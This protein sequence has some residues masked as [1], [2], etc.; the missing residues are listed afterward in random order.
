MW[1]TILGRSPI[2]VDV[3]ESVL[4]GDNRCVFAIHLPE[5]LFEDAAA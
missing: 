2:R 5:E 3:V 4:R 1:E